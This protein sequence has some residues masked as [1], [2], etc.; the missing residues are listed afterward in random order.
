MYKQINR[1]A[2]VRRR[3]FR[4]RK[5][6]SGTPESPRLSVYRSNKH[7]SVQVI[8]DVSML[9]LVSASTQE[10]VVREAITSG[11][12]VNAATKIGELIAKRALEKGIDRVVFDRGGNLYHGRIEALASAAREAGLT[13]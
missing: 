2:M 11:G 8:D 9:T 4:I 7:I 1:K 6:L 5:R 13:F 12:N 10:K 3:H